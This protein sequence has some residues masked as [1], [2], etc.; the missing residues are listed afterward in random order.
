MDYMLFASIIKSFL[1]KEIHKKIMKFVV[2]FKKSVPGPAVYNSSRGIT[3]KTK[4]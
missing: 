4:I 2:N 3:S 1:T